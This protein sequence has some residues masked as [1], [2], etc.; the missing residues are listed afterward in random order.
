MMNIRALAA[1]RAAEQLGAIRRS[2]PPT[3]RR[4]FAR[5]VAGAAVLGG[6]LESGFLRPGLADTRTAVLDGALESSFFRPELAETRWSF[7]PVPIPAGGGPFHVF[8]PGSNGVSIDAE[9][10]TITNLDGFVG[11]AYLSGM[12]TQ[13]NTK[14][15]KK[16]RL[17]F[18]DADMRFMQGEFRGADG[19]I[20]SGTFAFV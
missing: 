16:R 13:T 6:A 19:G 15:G 4:Q 3:T 20:H 17:P 2:P 14:T 8:P 10:S 11:L 9:P 7:A 12:V 18:I 1:W 5:A